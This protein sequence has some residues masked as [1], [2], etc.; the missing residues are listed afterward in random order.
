MTAA[1][2]VVTLAGSFTQGGYTNDAGNVARFMSPSGVCIS[3][4]II[5]VADTGNHRIR[6]ITFNPSPQIV[7]GA[8]LDLSTYA[9][10]KI[11][12]VVGRTYRIESSADMTNWTTHA[13]LL[14][15][16]SPYVWIDQNPVSGNKFYRAFLLP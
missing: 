8:N 4:G 3:Q 13:T 2:N 15:N 10:L 9:G 7:S 14:L 6:T 12:G 11:T 1:T 5:F 16:S